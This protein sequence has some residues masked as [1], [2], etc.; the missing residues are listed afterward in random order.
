MKQ[1][2]TSEAYGKKIVVTIEI[3]GDAK[4]K[5]YKLSDEM[6]EL[7]KYHGNRVVFAIREQLRKEYAASRELEPVM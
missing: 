1:T 7:V 6:T 2:A 5:G 4:S 3:E